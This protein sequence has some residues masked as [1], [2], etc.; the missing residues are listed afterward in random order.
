MSTSPEDTNPT[1]ETPGAAAE[2]TRA[3]GDTGAGNAFLEGTP[4][5][6][7]PTPGGLFAAETFSVIGLLLFALTTVHTRLFELFSWFFLSGAAPSH[8]AQQAA[9]LSAEVAVAG[10]LSALSVLAAAVALF[11]GGAATRAWSRWCAAATVVVG[12][13]ML[14]VSV[15]TFA[16]LPSG[17]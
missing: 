16:G 10:G 12:S 15:L 11:R 1:D 17:S 8:S 4:V 14:I 13:L 3:A 7:P 9:V 2:E 6:P 5:G